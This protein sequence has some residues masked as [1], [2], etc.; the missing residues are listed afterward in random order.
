MVLYIMGDADDTHKKQIV[1]GRNTS[2]SLWI[3]K[4]N[5]SNSM[6]NCFI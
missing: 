2:L 6:A 1:Q 3:V 4:A 5:K